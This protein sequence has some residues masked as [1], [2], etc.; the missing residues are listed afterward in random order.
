MF[1][2]HEQN[3]GQYHNM[4]TGNKFFEGVEQFKYLGTHI[5]NPNCIHEEIKS[6]Q[7]SG[8]DCYH[9]VQNLSSSSSLYKNIKM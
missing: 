6:R 4:K 5:T 9:S 1:S 8:N 2:S 7:K 3:A